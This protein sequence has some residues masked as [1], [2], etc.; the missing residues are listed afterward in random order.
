MQRMWRRR[1]PHCQPRGW[2]SLQSA[3]LPER[4]LWTSMESRQVGKQKY[5]DAIPPSLGAPFLSSMA[6][7]KLSIVEL[8]FE[9]CYASK[10]LWRGWAKVLKLTEF[11]LSSSIDGFSCNLI[12]DKGYIADAEKEILK[13]VRTNLLTPYRRNA[14]RNNYLSLEERKRLYK[15]HKIENVFCRMDKFRRIFYRFDRFISSF[16]CWHYLAMSIMT[17]EGLNRMVSD[18]SYRTAMKSRFVPK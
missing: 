9:L 4:W 1:R 5:H 3:T 15:R 18:K 10:L 14:V 8:C 7:R 12:G 6:S 17:V 2:S 13:S 16:S 11:T